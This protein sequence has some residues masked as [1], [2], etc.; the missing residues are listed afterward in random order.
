[1]HSFYLRTMYHENRLAIPGGISLV[2]VA[3]NLAQIKTPT[4]LLS[5]RED[6]I[7]PRRTRSF[8]VT[9]FRWEFE[10]KNREFE[11]GIVQI[12]FRMTFSEGTGPTTNNTG[13][14]TAPTIG[15]DGYKPT[16]LWA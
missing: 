1:M 12:D 10:R 2:G 6:H 16:L 14:I 15:A 9:G 11:L 8:C 7:A 13:Y 3:I 4:F 5:T